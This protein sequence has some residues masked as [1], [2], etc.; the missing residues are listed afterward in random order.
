MCGLLYT[1][2]IDYLLEQVNRLENQLLYLFSGESCR[3]GDEKV[4]GDVDS[5]DLVIVEVEACPQEF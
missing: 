1:Y 5:I 2:L 4:E 3:V